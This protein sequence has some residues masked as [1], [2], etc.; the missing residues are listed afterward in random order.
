[1]GQSQQGQGVTEQLNMVTE[2]H[3]FDALHVIEQAHFCLCSSSSLFPLIVELI[4]V[5]IRRI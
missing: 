2:G 5:H 3:F 1:M 4:A